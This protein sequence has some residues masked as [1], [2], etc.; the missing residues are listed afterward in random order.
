MIKKT[1]QC[2]LVGLGRMTALQAQGQHGFN[3]FVGSGMS[4]DGGGG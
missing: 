2:G 3:G 4:Q 1:T